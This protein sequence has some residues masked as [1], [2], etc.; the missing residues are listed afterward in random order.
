MKEV[1]QTTHAIIFDLDGLIISSEQVVRDS[2][3]EAA[4]SHGYDMSPMYHRLIGNCRDKSNAIL[5]EFF[6]NDFPLEELREQV[7]IIVDRRI[8]NGELSLKPGIKP[9]LEKLNNTEKKIGLATSSS[10][11]WI[12]RA[13]VPQGIAHHFEV[14]VTRDHVTK[15]KPDPECYLT[16]AERLG[17]A[18]EDCLVLEDSH[19]GVQAALN[20][21]MK[22][23]MVPDLIEPEKWVY[24]KGIPVLSSLE[25]LL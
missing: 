2:W 22:V 10:M 16:V 15:T 4:H 23:F 8:D 18:P 21:Q 3:H 20:A 17:V 13:L 24:A 1:L 5:E 12:E 19:Q 14:I 11:N 9:L 6:G 7:S 25:E